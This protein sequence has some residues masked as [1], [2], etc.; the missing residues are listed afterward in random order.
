MIV[1]K[2]K[3]EK[4]IVYVYVTRREPTDLSGLYTETFEVIN[5]DTISGIVKA[6]MECSDVLEVIVSTQVDGL[7]V[8]LYEDNIIQRKTKPELNSF[9]N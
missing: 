3:L 1:P 6:F 7:D 4:V 5:H 8:G 9:R 2:N